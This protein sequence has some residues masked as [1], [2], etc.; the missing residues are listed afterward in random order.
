MKIDY[1]Y[2]PERL[3]AKV[4]IGVNRAISRLQTG[5]YAAG[6]GGASYTRFCT[7]INH[8]VC[9]LVTG[10]EQTY[11]SVWTDEKIKCTVKP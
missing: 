5:E 3:D 10:K 11:I 4:F 7:F 8:C 2:N 6:G 1:L 9:L